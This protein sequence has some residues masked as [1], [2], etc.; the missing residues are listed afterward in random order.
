MP[1]PIAAI[2]VGAVVSGITGL[3][4]GAFLNK[5][6]GSGLTTPTD[7]DLNSFIDKSKSFLVD[8]TPTGLLTKS[9][10]S[11]ISDKPKKETFAPDILQDTKI[12]IDFTNYINN[13]KKRNE[14]LVKEVEKINDNI[15]NSNAITLPEL[16]KN[17]AIGSVGAI[18]TFSKTL[19]EGLTNIDITLVGLTTIMQEMVRLKSVELSLTDDYFKNHLQ[20]MANQPTANVTVESPNITVDVPDV[21]VAPTT[22]NVTPEIKSELSL[23]DTLSQ[24][25]QNSLDKRV[26]K[27]TK[28]IDELDY[29]KTTTA[30][31]DLDGNVVAEISPREIEAIKNVSDARLRT[32]MNN[33][34]LDSED[35]DIMDL[36]SF[37]ISKMFKFEKQ[38]DLEEDIL[39]QFFENYNKQGG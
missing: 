5:N 32:D 23:P 36:S 20:A 13:R 39:K 19:S 28:L 6:N 24:K 33:F 21:Q 8:Y 38:S 26:E 37:D 10:Y 14:S 12:D 1:I 9:L 18:S 22:V 31:K 30:V 3:I 35:F 2:G 15:R 34:E 17:N 27:D 29:R 7:E 25:W 16:L 4:G 11:I